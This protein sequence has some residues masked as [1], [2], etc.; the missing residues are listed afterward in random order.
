MVGTVSR[1]S[2]LPPQA[3]PVEL[4]NRRRI[5]TDRRQIGVGDPLTVGNWHP[6]FS[7]WDRNLGR[8]LDWTCRRVDRF[9]LFFNQP[10]S[11]RERPARRVGSDLY[12]F[13]RSRPG[14]L[15]SPLAPRNHWVTAMDLARHPARVRSVNQ[16][17]DSSHFFLRCDHSRADLG[18]RSAYPS[19]AGA[20]R[21][22]PRDAGDLQ[23]VGH[24]VFIRRW[25]KWSA[26]GLAILDLSNHVARFRSRSVPLANL[27]PEFSANAQEFFTL[28]TVNPLVMDQR[29]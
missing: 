19:A 12:L 8:G 3:P 17:A 22:H 21:G 20:R 10:G 5:Q 11:V 2:A 9:D 16:R 25:P 29:N 28:D 6:G 13:H 1:G 7:A 4:V 23:F 24:T 26:R 15:A 27:A 14:Y 18:E